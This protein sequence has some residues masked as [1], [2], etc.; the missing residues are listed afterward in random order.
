MQPT[1]H[2]PKLSNLTHTMANPHLL[3]ARGGGNARGNNA[4][5]SSFPKSNQKCPRQNVS[6]PMHLRI[7]NAW[8]VVANTISHQGSS[9]SY[10]VLV[11]TRQGTISVCQKLEQLLKR[12]H[13]IE[14]GAQLLSESRPSCGIGY[15]RGQLSL[16][17]QRR[18]T[19]LLF[20]FSLALRTQRCSTIAVLTVA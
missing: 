14:K 13:D 15:S 8:A 19:C 18:R 7:H 3:Q 10:I 17:Y 16:H 6:L 2:V 5:W 12:S 9:H 1:F 20:K 11:S 4:A